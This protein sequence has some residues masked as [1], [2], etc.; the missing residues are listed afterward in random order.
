MSAREPV[1]VLV[2]FDAGVWWADEFLEGTTWFSSPPRY[3][4]GRIVRCGRCAHAVRNGV[5]IACAEHLVE[6]VP[7]FFCASGTDRADDA[8]SMHRAAIA[9]WVVFGADPRLRLVPELRE[10]WKGSARNEEGEGHGRRDE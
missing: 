10:S 4:A 8:P 3:V 7:R 2:G 9:R 5:R 6:V 1:E